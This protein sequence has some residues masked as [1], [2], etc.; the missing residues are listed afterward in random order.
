MCVCKFN[1]LVGP[2]IWEFNNSGNHVA[3][4]FA[5]DVIGIISGNRLVLVMVEADPL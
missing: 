2:A 5:S 1:Y 3:V 4:S